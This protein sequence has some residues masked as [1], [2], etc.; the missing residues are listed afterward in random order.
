MS[1]ILVVKSDIVANLNINQGFSKT[2]VDQLHELLQYGLFEPRDIME[3]NYRFKQIIPYVLI[4]YQSKILLYKRSEMSDEQRLFNKYSVG[5]GGHVEK[6]D[7][8]L[9][10]ENSYENNIGNFYSAMIREV[11]EEIG[12]NSS[13]SDFKIIGYINDDSND[14][15]KVHLGIVAELSIYNKNILFS[16]EK[17]IIINRELVNVNE[18]KQNEEYLESWSAIIFREYL[19]PRE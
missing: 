16:G 2:T 1:E 10:V 4:F 18:I 8:H 17:D 5:I 13:K 12:I 3:K 11:K 6:D 9:V 7:R 14:V 15:G 19:H